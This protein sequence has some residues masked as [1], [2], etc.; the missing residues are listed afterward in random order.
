MFVKT[1]LEKII[2]PEYIQTLI[3]ALL[4][5]R[6]FQ[7]NNTVELLND[8]LIDYLDDFNYVKGSK[9]KQSLMN[10]N[11]ML[12]MLLTTLVENG[13][14]NTLL[15]RDEA[16][17]AYK[18]LF[19][20][21]RFEKHYFYSKNP[22]PLLT[23]WLVHSTLWKEANKDAYDEQMMGIYKGTVAFDKDDII[24]QDMLNQ[25][26]AQEEK[27][28]KGWPYPFETALE[29]QKDGTY[30]VAK[31]ATTAEMDDDIQARLDRLYVSARRNQHKSIMENYATTLNQVSAEIDA[32]MPTENPL[33]VLVV[34][35]PYGSGKTTYTNSI[36]KL[37]EDKSLLIELSVDALN[38]FMVQQNKEARATRSDYHF[39]AAILKDTI[40]AATIKNLFVTGAYV[41]N[42]RFN[43]TIDRDYAGRNI[44]IIEI[45]PEIPENAVVRLCLRE[46][47]T[48]T[49][50]NS[51]F[52][53]T[54]STANI[55]QNTREVR[56]NKVCAHDNTKYPIEYELICNKQTETGKPDFVPVCSVK[57][58]ELT[59]HAPE[60]YEK[61]T[62]SY[63][64]TRANIDKFLQVSNEAEIN[65]QTGEQLKI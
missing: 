47:I 15:L 57:N 2:K 1:E 32:L 46:K 7:T 30:K 23:H 42:Y 6:I 18:K 59:K 3:D 54:L 51:T 14:D 8:L 10:S 62:N 9:V 16:A 13:D 5:D 29:D 38:D 55:A 31:W 34:I 27:G 64:A 49:T 36:F 45:A 58:G 33:N 17:N 12:Y 65:E 50:D 48:V 63:T 40:N 41:D 28:K 43:K 25:I 60:L 20:D 56:I 26:K 24:S 22:L 53:N 37:K 4:N 21:S 39:E 19:E 44:K 11:P 61:L 35:G 52:E